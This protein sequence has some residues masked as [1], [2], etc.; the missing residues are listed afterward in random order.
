MANIEN[1][2]E[3]IRSLEAFHIFE[4]SDFVTTVFIIRMV[5]TTVE[6]RIIELM[7]AEVRSDSE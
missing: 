1:L 4:L 7:C 5:A 6:R 3:N 2:Y